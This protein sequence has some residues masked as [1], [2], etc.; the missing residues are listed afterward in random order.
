MTGNLYHKKPKPLPREPRRPALV[1]V[2]VDSSD[3]SQD[4]L[5]TQQEAMRRYRLG[6]LSYV[7]E[8]GYCLRLEDYNPMRD[9]APRI[10]EFLLNAPRREEYGS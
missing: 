2:R 9:S 4:R 5:I 7:P 10:P 8:Q 6:E 3:V 1:S